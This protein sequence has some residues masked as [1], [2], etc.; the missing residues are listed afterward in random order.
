MRL[1]PTGSNELAED[2]PKPWPLRSLEDFAWQAQLHEYE[3]SLIS[4]PMD[5]W[6]P[7][8]PKPVK[9]RVRSL[10]T[11][12]N[13]IEHLC[14]E[15]SPNPNRHPGRALFTLSRAVGTAAMISF[16]RR[17]ILDGDLFFVGREG[18]EKDKWMLVGMSTDPDGQRYGLI[19]PSGSR[20]GPL[21]NSG[22]HIVPSG[23]H[24]EGYVW[25][26]DFQYTMSDNPEGLYIA[27]G[28]TLAQAL[29]R[30]ARGWQDG[31]RDFL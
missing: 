26:K 3:Q 12:D 5:C 25:K 18:D 11:I 30:L 15:W 7:I 29:V 23:C 16:F 19:L 27:E 22:N 2:R 8:P 1:Q 21:D 20:L 14:K 28:E 31:K 4:T 24:H 17:T 6:H 13:A 9:G 10:Q